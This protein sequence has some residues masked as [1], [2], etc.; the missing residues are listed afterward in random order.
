MRGL[1]AAVGKAL[2][3]IMMMVM[4]WCEELAK[5][6]LKCRPGYQPADPQEIV[7]AYE[8]AAVAKD[9]APKIDEKIAG[10]QAAAEC[11]LRQKPP[12][13]DMLKGLSPKTLKW[14]GTLDAD[15]LNAVSKVK[16]QTLADHL[17]LKMQISGLLRFEDDAIDA[18]R[19]AVEADLKVPKRPSKS[20]TDD[21]TM[22][23]AAVGVG[24]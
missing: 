21:V 9:V 6:V 15:M 3:A 2:A 11:L 12:T 17:A 19:A 16:P 13:P 4:V 24:R 10:I 23:A 22:V 8:D 5:F 18:Y 1:I 14:L 7:D 20:R